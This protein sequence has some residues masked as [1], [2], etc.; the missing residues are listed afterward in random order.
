[1]GVLHPADFFSFLPPFAFFF[2]ITGI[3]TDFVQ[4]WQSDFACNP[5]GDG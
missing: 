4:S 5:Y 3:L 1:M 2:V